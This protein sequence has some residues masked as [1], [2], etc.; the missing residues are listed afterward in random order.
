MFDPVTRIDSRAVPLPIAN[1]D[2][3]IIIRI[4]R[5]TGPD[6]DQVGPWAFES[7]RYDDAGQPRPDF[8][9]NDPRWQ[10]AEI[11]VAGENFGCGSSREAAVTAILQAG[12]RC[13]IAESFGDIFYA[14][15][16]QNGLLPIRLERADVAA[17]MDAARRQERIAVD[18]EAQSISAGTRTWRFDIDPTRRTALLEGLDDM[19][20]TMKSIGEIEA[21][22]AQDRKDR[23]WIWNL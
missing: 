21:W 4:E 1:I 6:R 13:V 3:D 2:T 23:P 11:M 20:L 7:L 18:L 10:G 8:P 14:N 22:Q 5:L 16:F 9:M 17:L 12:L 19:G 15:C